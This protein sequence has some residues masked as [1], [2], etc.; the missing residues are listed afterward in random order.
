MLAGGW[1]WSSGVEAGNMWTILGPR[2]YR[3]KKKSLETVFQLYLCKQTN[4][5]L[6]RQKDRDTF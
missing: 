4:K 3:K 2:F 5:Q 6:E 1:F